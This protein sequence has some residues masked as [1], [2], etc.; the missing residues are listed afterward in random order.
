[1]RRV[2]VVGNAGVGKTTLAA[3]LARSLAVP[4][5][6]LDARYGAAMTDPRWAHLAFVRLRSAREAAAFLAAS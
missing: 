5:V 4:H 2:S 3:A 1:V 6:E